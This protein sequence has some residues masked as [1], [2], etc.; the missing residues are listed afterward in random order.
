M[1]EDLAPRISSLLTDL[2]PSPQQNIH[3]IVS[4]TC[5]LLSCDGASMR[6]SRPA[7]TPCAS[8]RHATYRTT[9]CRRAV[10]S[11]TSFGRSSPTAGRGRSVRSTRPSGITNRAP[12][13]APG[14]A[15]NSFI[16]QQVLVGGLSPGALAALDMRRRDFTDPERLIIGLAA[17]ALAIEEGRLQREQ[18]LE[19]RILFEKTLKD[20]STMAIAV[21]DTLPFVRRCLE[22]AGKLLVTGGAFL[23]KFD[24][25]KNKLGLTAE[26]VAAGRPSRKEQLRE[27]AGD[28]L[29]ESLGCLMNGDILNITDVSAM[30]AGRERELAEGLGRRAVLVVPLFSRETF[31]GFV[32]FKEDDRPRRWAEEDIVT[33]QTAAEIVMRAIENQQLHE[34]LLSHR[35]RLERAVAERTTALRRADARCTMEIESH[36]CTIATLTEREAELAEKSKTFEELNTTLA[37]LL[38]RRENDLGDLEERMVGNIR[39]LLD[40]AIKH[41][42]SGGLTDTQQKWLDVLASNLNELASPFSR[43]NH[44]RLPPAH[45]HG[46]QGGELHQA[47]QEQQ[48]DLRFPGHLRPHG[49]GPP[50]QY[51]PQAGDKE[52][53]A[54]LENLPDVDRVR[55]PLLLCKAACRSSRARFSRVESHRVMRCA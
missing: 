8:A 25:R 48:G 47:Q 11:M 37:V 36:K 4:K 29:A 20:M 44:V 54:E 30:P 53:Q 7:A 5:E 49:G 16:G 12:P 21:D 33:L 50:Q 23:W 39:D 35:L 55:R 3:A 1:A 9:Q 52:P 27:I 45:P 28:V 32:G 6:A 31:F 46:D 13:P 19:R 15:S 10:R 2:G 51:P 38:K 34:E 22:M 18:A 42:K 24:S 26:W 14:S 17:R 43:Q 40:P 41:L